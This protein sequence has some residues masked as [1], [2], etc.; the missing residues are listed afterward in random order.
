MKTIPMIQPAAR[1]GFARVVVGIAGT[2]HLATS[3]LLL[4]A[5][6]SYFMLLEHF[7]P[8]NRHDA[9]DLGAFQLPLGVGLLLAAREPLR[10]RVVIV[11]AAT[12]N[13]LHAL[14]HI[15]EGLISPTTPVYWIAD[16]GML[17]VMTIALYVTYG[18]L[19]QPQ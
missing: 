17:I 9:G 2:I 14:N 15:Y 18:G 19:E 12:A 1:L 16:V 6:Y 7:P 5:P 4:L 13:L 8:Y 11:I 3:L 10:Y